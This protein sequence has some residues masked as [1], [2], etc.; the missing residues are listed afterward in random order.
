MNYVYLGVAIIA[1]VTATSFLKSSEGMTKLWP[2]LASVTGYAVSFYFLSITLKVIPTG[3]AYG[4]WS[5]VGIVLVSAV[6]WLWFARPTPLVAVLA[7]TVALAGAAHGWGRMI[8]RWLDDGDAPPSLAIGWGVAAYLVVGRGL[9]AAGL[10]GA[11]ARD[12][13]VVAGLLLGLAWA[14]GARA[15]E[16]AP[17]R[18][19]RAAAD[20]DDDEEPARTHPSK[21]IIPRGAR[22]L[23]GGALERS[24]SRL[25]LSRHLRAARRRARFHRNP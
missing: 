24:R 4:I 14:A 20:V 6:G 3:I 12:V 19:P 10:L 11:F 18:P 17:L 9:A 7:A 1:E 5:G 15:A 2:T 25:C 21:G 8:G 13:I 22:P 16:I 23:R